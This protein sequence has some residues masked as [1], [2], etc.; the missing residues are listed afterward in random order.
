MPIE[1]DGAARY[2]YNE[3]VSEYGLTYKSLIENARRYKLGIH[4]GRTRLFTKEEIKLF[5]EIKE[6]GPGQP[7]HKKNREKKEK[8]T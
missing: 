3:I 2:T 6:R 7:S 4:I 8:K 5:I 1:I